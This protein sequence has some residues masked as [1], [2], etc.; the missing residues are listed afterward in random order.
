MG[1]HGPQGGDERG[2]VLLVRP[3]ANPQPVVFKSKACPR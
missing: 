2:M 3:L 1:H